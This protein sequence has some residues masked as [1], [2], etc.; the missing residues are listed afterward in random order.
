MR[1]IGASEVVSALHLP[2]LI[3]ALR[4]TFRHDDV[5]APPSEHHVI[6]VPGRGHGALHVM[7]AWQTGSHLGVR[8]AT[9]F[10]GANADGHEGATGEYLLFDA[11]NGKTLALFDGPAL[12]RRRAAA[13]SALAASYLA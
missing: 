1:V 10:P 9:A 8:L 3:E 5:H 4:T 13:V 2:D 11:K 12:A 7:P 6:D